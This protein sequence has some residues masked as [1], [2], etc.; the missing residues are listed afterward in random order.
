[1]DP[2][3]KQDGEHR[4][5]GFS[6]SEGSGSGKG[7]S[8]FDD[9]DESFDA[10]TGARKD[11]TPPPARPQPFDP[12]N[13]PP[14]SGPS[15]P[16]RRG[17][18]QSGPQRAKFGVLNLASP[19][20]TQLLPEKREKPDDGGWT[21]DSDDIDMDRVR[22]AEGGAAGPSGPSGPQPGAKLQKR[23]DD[24][25]SAGE[26]FTASGQ[27]SFVRQQPMSSEDEV[28]GEV[29]KRFWGRG[30]MRMK[31]SPHFRK[32]LVSFRGRVFL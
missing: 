11:K 18:P 9:S 14:S 21:S 7:L 25:Q 22:A 8:D 16:S 3:Q 28:G 19:P 10:R 13:P 12:L 6:D 27:L 20:K 30:G 17:G 32:M 23:G 15:G 2:L 29:G 26:E 31:A 4:V 1:M 5:E 24:K